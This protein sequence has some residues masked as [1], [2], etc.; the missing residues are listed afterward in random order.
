MLQAIVVE[1]LVY[2]YRAEV[3]DGL[4]QLG[5]QNKTSKN[6]CLISWSLPDVKQECL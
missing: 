1:S 2:L 3:S 5:G 4:W 6:L